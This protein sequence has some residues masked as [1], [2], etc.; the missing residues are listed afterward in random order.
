MTASSSNPRFR[1]LVVDDDVGL[2]ETTAALL[3]DDCDVQTASGG[4][5]A[6]ALFE[7]SP[8]DVVCT[9]YQMPGISGLELVRQLRASGYLF[10]AVLVTGLREYAGSAATRDLVKQGA[11]VRVLLKPYDPQVLIETVASAANLLRMKRAVASIRGHGRDGE[12][13]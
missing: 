11:I 8:V 13:R 5:E 3:T 4:E 6:L 9:D 10:G 7:R 12:V 1:V 2:L